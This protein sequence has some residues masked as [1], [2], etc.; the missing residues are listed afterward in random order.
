MGRVVRRVVTSLAAATFASGALLGVEALLV[1]RREFLSADTAPPIGG[2]Y[3]RAFAPPLRLA[4]LGDS[5]AAGVGVTRVEDSVGARL[6]QAIADTGRF[7]T[8]DGLGVSGSRAADLAPQVSRALTHPPDVAVILIGANDATHLTSLDA[9]RRDVRAAVER[10]R[11]AGVRVVVA[12]CPDMGAPTAFLPPLRQVVALEGRRIG[13]V[14][15]AAAR[16]AGAVTVDLAA[17]TGPAFRADRATY[18][19]SDRF[20]P[21]AAGYALWAAALADEV[22]AAAAQQ[23]VG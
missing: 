17:E 12:T 5:T 3:G 14:T 18:L 7:V 8:L 23:S 20:H 21:S 9:V 4:I 11:A 22:R 6:A 19:S 16:A 2:T 13:T 15:G 1:T 10:L